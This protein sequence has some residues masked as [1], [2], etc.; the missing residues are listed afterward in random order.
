MRYYRYIWKYNFVNWVIN[1]NSIIIDI[2]KIYELLIINWIIIQF[3]TT[4]SHSYGLL[5]H[6][7]SKSTRQVWEM[8]SGLIVSEG[9]IP[10]FTS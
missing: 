6:M 9:K 2:I 3:G 5:D 7:L 1:D 10:I 4:I 8:P